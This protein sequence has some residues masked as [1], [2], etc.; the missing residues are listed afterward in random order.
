[1]KAILVLVF[2]GCA[3]APTA[4]AHL[5]EAAPDRCSAPPSDTYTSL[6][7]VKVASVSVR[8][9]GFDA[10]S[11]TATLATKP[12]VPFDPGTLR[13]DVRSL[14]KLGASQIAVTAEPSPDGYAIELAV[15]PLPHVL[16]VEIT[17]ATRTQL[18]TLVVL[19]GT[20]HDQARLGRLTGGTQ[21]WLRTHGYPRAVLAGESF[22]TCEGVVVRIDAKLGDHFT[23][24]RIAVTGSAVPAPPLMFEHDLGK[25]NVVGGELDESAFTDDLETLVR[26]HRDI[27]YL[28]A[29]LVPP[30][31]HFDD[32]HRLV[33]ADARIEPGVRFKVAITIQGGTPAQ[34]ALA[35]AVYGPLRGTWFDREA[36]SHAW[37]RLEIA[38]ADVVR[39]HTEV[40]HA[41]GAY[42]EVVIIKAPS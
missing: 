34:R 8:G 9:V 3:H 41:N 29:N 42:T 2:V 24:S 17:G 31:V 28:D 27:G 10:A 7:G 40:S 39:F 18:A 36:E 12:G 32:Q 13:E 23:L 38:F 33:T 6:T 11:M 37:Q 4:P 15:V 20:L 26:R 16:R 35:E 19:E 25:M 5:P 30:V 21:Q 1:M 14:W 22:P